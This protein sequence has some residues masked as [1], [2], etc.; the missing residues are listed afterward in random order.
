[1]LELLTPVGRMVQGNP[2]D[3][4]TKNREGR[5]LTFKDGSPRADY[6]FAIAIEKTNPGYGGRC[7]RRLVIPL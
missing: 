3:G 6:F 5:P 1:M 7:L 2:F 4:R